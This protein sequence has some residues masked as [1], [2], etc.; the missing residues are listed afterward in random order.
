MAGTIKSNV[1][2]G[3]SLT[4]AQNFV[5]T[6]AAADGTLKLARGNAGA[7]TQDILTVDAAGIMSAVG[8]K[9]IFNRGNILGTVS[10]TAGVP[11]GAVI[12]RGSNANGEYVR[13]ADGTLICYVPY[14]G[15]V[16]FSATTVT[17]LQIVLITLAA[18]SASTIAFAV[19]G[20]GNHSGGQGWAAQSSAKS[21]TQ[22]ICNY[23]SASNATTSTGTDLL[24]TAI[25][26]WF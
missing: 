25:G 3:D 21:A 5:L 13:F 15:A 6:A 16:T 8:G 1:Q 9:L 18:P 14:V 11:T 20:G 2:L 24:I 23:Y 17:G 10:Q 4:A 12:E 26:R 7:T 22:I 19:N